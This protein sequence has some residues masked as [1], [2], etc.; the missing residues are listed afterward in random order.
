MG[1]YC[2]NSK[3]KTMKQ[4][5]LLVAILATGSICMAQQKTKP[6]GGYGAGTAEITWLDGKPVLAIGGYGG[7]LINHKLL[8]GAA[9]SNLLFKE[10]VNGIKEKFQFN[11]YGLFAEYKLYPTQ[12]VHLSAAVTTAIGWL[13]NDIKSNEK[14]WKKDG[15]YTYV[16]QPKLALNIKVTRFMQAQV[17]TNYRITGDTKSIYYHSKNFNGASAGISLLFGAF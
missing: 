12:H 13:E 4:T 5:I 8:L 14:G 9:G 3:N 2:Q 17:Y 10:K 7:V 11:Y 1:N 6:I 15:D 16:I